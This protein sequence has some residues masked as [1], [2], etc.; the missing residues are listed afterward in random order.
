M[1][2]AG[3][4]ER[5]IARTR[6]TPRARPTTTTLQCSMTMSRVVQL[7]C[8]LGTA[9]ARSHKPPDAR[10][11]VR[12]TRPKCALLMLAHV[13]KTGG[14]TV[15]EVLQALPGKW[16]FLGRP[17]SGH[18]RFFAMY[19]RLFAG[20][21]KLDTSKCMVYDNATATTSIEGGCAGVPNWRASKIV[22]D[23]HEPRGL[24]KFHHVVV[25][26]LRPLRKWYAAAGCAMQVGLVLREPTSQ[27]LSEYLYFHVQFSRRLHGNASLQEATLLSTWLPGHANPQLA[28]M[29]ARSCHTLGLIFLCS[30]PQ[31]EPCGERG[32]GGRVAAPRGVGGGGDESVSGGDGRDDGPLTEDEEKAVASAIR[33]VSEF[34]VVGTSTH[35][36]ALIWS[37]AAR[38]GFFLERV[39]RP[40]STLSRAGEPDISDSGSGDHRGSG[41]LLALQQQRLAP[42][43]NPP[44]RW[45]MISLSSVAP[46]TLHALRQHSR[47]DRK[48]FEAALL[49]EA[50]ELAFIAR[51]QSRLLRPAGSSERAHAKAASRAR[52][53]SRDVG[54]DGAVGI[55]SP[56]H[57][58]E[59]PMA[60][61]DPASAAPALHLH[62]NAQHEAAASLLDG[63]TP[64]RQAGQH[65]MLAAQW[66]QT[67]IGELFAAGSAYRTIETASLAPPFGLTNADPAVLGARS[68]A[69]LAERLVDEPNTTTFFCKAS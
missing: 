53:Q 51:L 60:A 66:A 41:S 8:W 57:A 56:L 50:A 54:N 19:G 39:D 47:C 6:S 34:D 28:W 58:H 64:P 25:P 68:H 37:L 22:V 15:S 61:G 18:P 13:P 35:V 43:C 5:A 38:V 31:N 32:G 67:V 63:A 26:R 36:G 20:V 17:T 65:A 33:L 23:F 44:S 49:R 14:S 48:L 59:V 27:M 21:S 55:S 1:A 52:E 30:T 10:F 2:H 40:A 69:D 16:N 42:R 24:S 11:A 12:S 4:E 62:E 9:E 46:S 29:R 3:E 45:G 7:L